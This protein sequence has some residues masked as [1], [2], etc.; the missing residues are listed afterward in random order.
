MPNGVLVG[1][2]AL[3]MN[4]DDDGD[5]DTSVVRTVLSLAA[6][7]WLETIELIPG[8]RRRWILSASRDG[9][10][11]AR[12]KFDS[13]RDAQDVRDRIAAGAAAAIE[14]DWPGLIDAA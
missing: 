13:R 11:I 8:R 10:I 9:S 7:V 6:L 14:L 3:L 2:V 1:D 5:E 12:R 4:P